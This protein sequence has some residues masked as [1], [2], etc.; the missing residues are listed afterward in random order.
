MGL[1]DLEGALSIDCLDGADFE[2]EGKKPEAVVLGSLKKFWFGDV[3]VIAT[4]HAGGGCLC[5]DDEVKGSDFFKSVANAGVSQGG[6]AVV[7]V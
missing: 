1:W 7:G 2:L 4:Q 5:V 3:C 6:F